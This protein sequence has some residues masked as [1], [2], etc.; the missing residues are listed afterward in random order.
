[1]AVTSI[2]FTKDEER[3][4]EFLK[5]SLHS[6]A[7]SVIKKAVYE[8]YEDLRDR[9]IIQGFEAR[10]SGGKADFGSLDDILE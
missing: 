1:M 2:S 4:I 9:E 3:V 7:S 8:L 10:E 5:E 6:D